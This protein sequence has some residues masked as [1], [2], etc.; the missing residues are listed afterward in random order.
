MIHQVVT[1]GQSE[2][3]VLAETPDLNEAFALSTAWE[4][5]KP[6]K[7]DGRLGTTAVINGECIFVESGAHVW[8]A[9]SGSIEG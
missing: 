6:T 2:I 4:F 5:G 1:K 8:V 9:H 3:K 7:V